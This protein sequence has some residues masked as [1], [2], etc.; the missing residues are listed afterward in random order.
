MHPHQFLIKHAAWKVS[1]KS[2]YELK[3]GKRNFL[4]AL[5]PPLVSRCNHYVSTMDS[6]TALAAAAAARESPSRFQAHYQN[7]SA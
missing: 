5:D 4:A 6:S 7:Q 3:G 2:R 1:G